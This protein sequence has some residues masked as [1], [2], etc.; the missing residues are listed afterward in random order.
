MI[1]QVLRTRVLSRFT[2]GQENTA[3]VPEAAAPTN[4]FASARSSK[5][6]KHFNPQPYTSLR[7]ALAQQPTLTD[8]SCK[9]I[10]G[11][12][13]RSWVE[14][15]WETTGMHAGGETRANVDDAYENFF[16]RN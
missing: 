16:E 12:P 9:N 8:A 15:S 5:S 10:A 7:S 2:S 1:A 6:S 4:E 14:T 11:L 13:P 3:A